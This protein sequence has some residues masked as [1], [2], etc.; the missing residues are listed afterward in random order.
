VKRAR[1]GT[2]HWRFSGA[3]AGVYD[4]SLTVANRENVSLITAP[5]LFRVEVNATCIVR[6]PTMKL[7]SPFA[8]CRAASRCRFVSRTP[9]TRCTSRC[10]CRRAA[11]SRPTSPSS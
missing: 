1:S 8:S 9:A 7:L 11:R 2:A 10:A 5:Y 3:L 4:V 6:Q